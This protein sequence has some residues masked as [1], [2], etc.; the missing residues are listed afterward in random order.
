MRKTHALVGVAVALLAEPDARHWG[1]DLGRRSGIRS[2]VLY[3]ILARMLR[4][5]WLTDGWED[6][7]TRTERRPP[8]RYYELTEHGKLE[9]AAT[10]RAARAD[11]RF[12]ALDLGWT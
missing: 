5:G 11:R 7:A 6:P 1:Y 2:G 9:L 8:R 4:E 10:V 12:S 3:P